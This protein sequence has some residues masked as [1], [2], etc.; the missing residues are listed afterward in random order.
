[1]VNKIQQGY[2]LSLAINWPVSVNIIGST[3][4]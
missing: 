4:V 2:F 1:M 3:S